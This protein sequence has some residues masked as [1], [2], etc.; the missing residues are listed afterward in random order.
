[1]QRQIVQ[2]A[3]GAASQAA[4][5]M[6]SFLGEIIESQYTDRTAWA[7]FTEHAKAPEVLLERT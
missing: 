2:A 1:L 7:L 5:F 6:P 4:F 3:L